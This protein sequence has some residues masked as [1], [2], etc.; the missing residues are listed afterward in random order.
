MSETIS[1]WTWPE[2]EIIDAVSTT[3][4]DRIKRLDV[5]IN[6]IEENAKIYATSA[7]DLAKFKRDAKIA[8]A[9]YKVLIE[10]VK[11]QTLAAG[12]QQDNFTVFEYATPPIA[13][14]SP[15]RKSILIIG[16]VLGMLMGF[17]LSL[18]NAIR[19]GVYYTRKTLI[20]DVGADL[21]FK[22]KF[23]RRISRKSIS[24]II[25]LI[26]K[27][28]LMALDE[29][30]LKLAN[31]R[32][33]YI[34]NAGGQPTSSNTARLL[35]T[36]SAQSGRNV[37]ICDTTGQSEKEITDKPAKTSSDITTV[38]MGDNINLM[39]GALKNPFSLP[40]N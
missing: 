2:I 9:T 5:D 27:R 20:S 32:I 14:S 3:L 25:L 6:N 21:N 17:A 31:K 33:I 16:A 22:S 10:Q 24:E 12:F 1:A 8:E 23:I 28:R 40:S 37:V 35:A 18:L 29:A 13:P 15:K 34:L 19:R 36:Y 30:T 39:I 38:R 11:S 7:E 4:K 26:S